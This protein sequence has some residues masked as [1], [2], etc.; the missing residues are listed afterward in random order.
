[1]PA[2]LKNPLIACEYFDWKLFKRNGV[3][4]ADG[5]SGSNPGDRFSLGT[6]DYDEA[7]RLLRVLDRKV[8]CWKEE[9]QKAG[10]SLSIKDGNDWYLGIREPDSQIGNIRPKTLE[11]YRQKLKHWEDYCQSQGVAAWNEI[12][13]VTVKKFMAKL[14]EDGRKPR[15]IYSYAT[16]IKQ[17]HKEMTRKKKLPADSSIDLKLGKVRGT[18]VHCY[19]P[20]EVSAILERAEGLTEMPWLYAPVVALAYTGVRISELVSLRWGDIDFDEKKLSIVDERHRSLAPGKVRQTKSSQTRHL[21]IH[22]KLL[23]VLKPLKGNSSDPV[24]LDERGKRINPDRFRRLFVKLIINPLAPRFP[25]KDQRKGFASGR[26]HS[27]RH[28][29]CSRMTNLGTPARMMLELMGHQDSEMTA[30]YYEGRID[31]CKSFVARLD[32]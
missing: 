7:L 28:A 1:M 30:H 31:E 13:E 8:G 5:R 19:T 27:F 17:V 25:I 11:G 2:K 9:E 21:P 24:F 26:F 18:D 32:W 16:L 6:S 29:F 15:T 22:E 14:T 20:E 23:S 4:H 10:K 3:Y 12:D